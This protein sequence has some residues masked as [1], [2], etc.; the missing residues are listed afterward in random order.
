MNFVLRRTTR[1]TTK[2]CYRLLTFFATYFIYS[3]KMVTCVS[4]PRNHPLT[5]REKNC[6]R[7]RRKT[8]SKMLKD[9]VA[10]VYTTFFVQSKICIHYKTNKQN[11]LH[12]NMN[13][14]IHFVN[15][16]KI[17]GREL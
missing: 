7:R 16:R 13:K 9:F 4:R 5:Y 17:V 12:C 10:K 8:I 11:L 15:D 6:H 3:T 1:Q 2:N 14:T